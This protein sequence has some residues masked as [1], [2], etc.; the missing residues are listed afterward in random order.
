MRTV[1]IT[2]PTATNRTYNGIVQE[3]FEEGSCT[4]G[5]VMYY[6]ITDKDFS[7]STWKQS[8]SFQ[9]A[10]ADMAGTYTLYYYCYVSDTSNNTGTGINTKKSMLFCFHNRHL[11]F[12]N[13]PHSQ[14]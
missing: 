10:S 12:I 9:N 1:T 7:T 11:L 2:A 5:G 3:I 8:L 4:E 6:S 14:K 13:I